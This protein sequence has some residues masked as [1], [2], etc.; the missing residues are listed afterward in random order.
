LASTIELPTTRAASRPAP[1][2]TVLDAS[3]DP[4]TLSEFWEAADK[5]IALIFVRHFG[6]PFCH[7][8]VEA[9]I[10]RHNAF[11]SAGIDIV[12]VGNGPPQQ[13]G[14]FS[15]EM[16]APFPVLTDPTGKAYEAYGLG[17]ASRGAM[18]APAAILGGIRAA[19]LGHLPKRPQGDPL[20]LPGQFL[21]DGNGVIWHADRPRRISD[22]PT[23][24]ALLEV[25]SAIW[26]T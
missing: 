5:G 22:V 23:A 9:L 7:A 11:L 1:D 6:C 25:G 2:A 15:H 10:H 21:I 12:V 13:A 19:L 4:H 20:Q 24:D 16:R 26:G 17:K 8:H 14:I 18:F 3:G